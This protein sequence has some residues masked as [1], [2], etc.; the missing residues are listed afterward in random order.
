M[1]FACPEF[2]QRSGI[3]NRLRFVDRL[4]IFAQSARFVSE[5]ARMKPRFHLGMMPSDTK[6]NSK[7]E[8]PLFQCTNN[9]TGNTG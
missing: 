3:L 1:E 2:N 9:V 6:L 7:T 5:L 8:E 4:R